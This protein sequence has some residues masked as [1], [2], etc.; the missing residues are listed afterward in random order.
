MF[1]QKD[2]LD[3]LSV[4]MLGTWLHDITIELMNL[5]VAK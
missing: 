5:N 3:F 1:G 2:P 4:K